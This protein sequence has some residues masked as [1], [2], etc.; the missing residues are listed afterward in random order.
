MSAP[1]IEPSDAREA[2][3]LLMARLVAYRA[4]KI[5]AA[6]LKQRLAERQDET[7]WA[8]AARREPLAVVQPRLFST[9]AE[10]PLLGAQSGAPGSAGSPRSSE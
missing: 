5:G 6:A 10:R 4:T 8:G 3:E 2:A 7:F 1:T 9:R